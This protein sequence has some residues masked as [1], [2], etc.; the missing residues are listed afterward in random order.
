MCLNS[1]YS[2]G[3][4]YPEIQAAY[5]DDKVT[6]NCYSKSTVKWTTGN[7]PYTINSP[8]RNILQLEH[9]KEKDYGYY[10]CHGM[11]EDDQIFTARSLLLVGG[12]TQLFKM[13]YYTSF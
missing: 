13:S 2:Y 8:L 4:V 1:A 10:E 6:I 3:S 7:P 5:I 12:M 9:V 11:D